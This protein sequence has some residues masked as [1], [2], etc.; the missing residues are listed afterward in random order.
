MWWQVKR[1]IEVYTDRCLQQSLKHEAACSL[2]YRTGNAPVSKL[3]SAGFDKRK[4]E[5]R[6]HGRNDIDL[7]DVLEL[8]GVRAVRI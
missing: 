5:R 7:L 8:V 4:G 1:S 3:S 6:I 2:G